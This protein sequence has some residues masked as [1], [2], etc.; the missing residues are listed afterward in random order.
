MLNTVKT[1]EIQGFTSP[2]SY[3]PCYLPVTIKMYK[4]S[5]AHSH[6]TKLLMAVSL[7]VTGNEQAV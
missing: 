2:V 7:T 3:A 6:Y 5:R 1:Q 4:R